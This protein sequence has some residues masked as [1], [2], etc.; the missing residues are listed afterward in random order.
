M[1]V[2][3]RTE[4]PNLSESR[5]RSA[6]IIIFAITTIT[7]TRTVFWGPRRERGSSAEAARLSAGG[8]PSAA[9]RYARLAASTCGHRKLVFLKVRSIPRRREE[10]YFD[11]PLATAASSSRFALLRSSLHHESM[12]SRLTK[13]C[14]SSKARFSAVT[15]NSAIVQQN[16]HCPSCTRGL[17]SAACRVLLR[18][19]RLRR[20]TN[21]CLTQLSQPFPSLQTQIPKQTFPSLQI[22]TSL[23]TFPSLQTQTSLQTFPSLQIQIWVLQTR[24]STYPTQHESMAPRQR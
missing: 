12:N 15:D 19:T 7:Y 6:A 14:F 23:Q 3:R 20:F 2:E 10:P 9:F 5:S 1:R 11:F 17:S 24:I 18:R 16:P 22:Q 21:A 8:Q 4:R 13:G